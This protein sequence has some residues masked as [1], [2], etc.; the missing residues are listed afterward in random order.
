MVKK[1]YLG[2]QR[3]PVTLTNILTNGSLSSNAQGWSKNTSYYT[4][5]NENGGLKVRQTSSYGS[6]NEESGTW[7]TTY[8]TFTAISGSTAETRQV[9]YL[10]IKIKPNPSNT[11]PVTIGYYYNTSNN[12]KSMRIQGIDSEGWQ[13][14]S[15]CVETYNSSTGETQS[16]SRLIFGFQTSSDYSHYDINDNSVYNEFYAKEA[17]VINLTTA[18]GAGNEPSREWCDRNI[19][20]FEGTGTINNKTILLE[21]LIPDGNMENSSWTYGNYSTSEKLFGSRSQYFVKNTNRTQIQN[22]MTAVPIVGHKYYGRH[23]LKT[24]GEVTA[25]DCRFEWYAGDGDGLNY[26]F[27]HNQGNY[28]DW[29]MESSIITVNAVNGSGY[30]CRSFVVN[31]TNN[32]WADG[33]MIIDLTEAFG[34]G[35]EPNKAWCDENIPFFVDYTYLNSTDLNYVNVPKIYIGINNVARRVIKGYIGING[36]ARKFLDREVKR[37]GYTTMATARTRM[38]TAK[39][40]SYAIFAGG[41]TSSPSKKITVI[42]PNLTIDNSLQLDTSRRDAVG[43]SFN[44]YAMIAGGNSGAILY[45]V[46]TGI[47]IYDSNLVKQTTV[48][49][50][51]RR[52]FLAGGA[53]GSYAVFAGGENNTTSQ[54]DLLTVEAFNTSFVKV[55]TTIDNLD[56][57]DSDYKGVSNLSAVSSGN[58]ILF[59]GGDNKGSGGRKKVDAYNSLLQ[60]TSCT[61]LSLP[62]AY[63]SSIFFNNK[64]I[65]A[66]GCYSGRQTFNNINI[67]DSSLVKLTDAE[68][69]YP[70]CEMGCVSLD[71]YLL[72]AGGVVPYKTRSGSNL[73]YWTN[74][75]TNEINV[76]DSSFILHNTF[77]F[78]GIGK[79]A[80]RHSV[81]AASLDKYAIFVGG[82]DVDSLGYSNIIDIFTL[83]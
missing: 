54:S 22:N 21:N 49:M 32:L 47:E 6:D 34:A 31:G 38:A 46:Q 83:D 75:T 65:F 3:E 79:A 69:P 26:V 55:S 18:F 82:T 30:V 52:M 4:Y 43:V 27:G 80:W 39:T 74:R 12:W 25:T 29:T 81:G 13:L 2:L 19:S 56:N 70:A 44:N 48:D 8:K 66:G 16:V 78:S 33:L 50:S 41:Y 35:N 11:C 10:R 61:E 72:F 24:N 42:S 7:Y 77:S 5:S 64:F 45:P 28:P 36:I 58:Y 37:F 73:S 17:M 51:V 62:A 68:L 60:K 40:N 63:Q 9:V 67:Y 23:Y 20:F 71:N 53:V 1:T 59:A 57:S 14:V 15:E 76:M